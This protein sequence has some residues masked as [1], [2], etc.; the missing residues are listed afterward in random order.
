MDLHHGDRRV[1]VHRLRDEVERHAPHGREDV[2]GLHGQPLRHRA[3]VRPPGGVDPVLVDVV[4][5]QRDFHDPLDEADVVYLVAGGVRAAPPRVPGLVLIGVPLHVVARDPV[6]VDHDSALVVGYVIE[7]GELP[8]LD[9]VRGVSVHV[10]D[11][12]DGHVGVQVLGHVDLPAPGQVVVFDAV[13]YP[14][15]GVWRRILDDQSVLVPRCT[16]PLR[17][18]AR[19]A[20]REKQHRHQG[21]DIHAAGG[22]SPPKIHCGQG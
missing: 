10:D 12:R 14:V 2:A 5:P 19:K 3:P 13:V 18:A 11:Q 4:H 17:E 9:R 15:L 22:A 8:V 20:G 21:P 6:R 7:G 1:A 16:V